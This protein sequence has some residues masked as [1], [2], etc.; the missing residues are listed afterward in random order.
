MSVVQLDINN[1]TLPNASLLKIYQFEIKDIDNDQLKK[2]A[3]DL[4]QKETTLKSNNI[5]GYHSKWHL[6]RDHPV[7]IILQLQ[8]II[9]NCTKKILKHNPFIIQSWVNIN[10]YGHSIKNHHHAVPLVACYY[11]TNNEHFGGEFVIA[12]T[13]VKIQPKAGMLLVFPGEI[14]HEV[15]PYN[16]KDTRISIACNIK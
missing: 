6:F 2:F 4:E 8:S 3:L 11:V 1:E 12:K 10:R 15:L 5:G 16:G 9:S 13:T 14:F 7:D